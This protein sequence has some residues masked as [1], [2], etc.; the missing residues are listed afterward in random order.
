MEEDL[1]IIKQE[2]LNLKKISLMAAK[3]VLTIEEAS[4]FTGLS[5]PRLYTLT[6]NKQIP[7]YKREGCRKCYF[8]KN[9]LEA[10]SKGVRITT[11]DEAVQNAAA[12]YAN[13]NVI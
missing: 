9:E 7:F 5:I 6:C 11:M 8:D 12:E 4:L 1:L 13:R 3:N 2:I 10:W